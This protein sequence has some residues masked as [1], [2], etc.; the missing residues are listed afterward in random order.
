MIRVILTH[1]KSKGALDYSKAPFLFFHIT[2]KDCAAL[3]VEKDKTERR[4]GYG[5]YTTEIT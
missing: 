1:V 3:G 4:K 5:Y 2:S